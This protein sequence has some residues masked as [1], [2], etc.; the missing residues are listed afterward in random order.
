M[1]AET[2]W[3]S[4]WTALQAWLWGQH[5]RAAQIPPYT[6]ALSYVPLGDGPPGPLSVLMF[7]AF[8]VPSGCQA[9]GRAPSPSTSPTMR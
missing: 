1:K 7:T 9:L 6:S 5:H 8:W 4:V 2:R 3:P